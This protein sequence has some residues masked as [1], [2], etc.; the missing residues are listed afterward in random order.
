[1]AHLELSKKFDLDTVQTYQV[2]GGIVASATTKTGTPNISMQKSHFIAFIITAIDTT[3]A[4]K[5]TAKVL[6]ATASTTGTKATALKSTT[7]AA[8]TGD[9]GKAKILEID[10]SEL[11]VAAGYD[12]V[13]LYLKL[14]GA[15]S[16]AVSVI[17]GPNRYSPL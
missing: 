10:A 2:P 16:V 5:I 11:D 8:G 14:A 17:R 3:L 12:F 9:A 15:D 13:S 7:F 6:E 1:M 4:G